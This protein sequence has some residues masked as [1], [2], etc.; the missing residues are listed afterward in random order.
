MDKPI[1][2]L[3]DLVIGI[4]QRELVEGPLLIYPDAEE[5]IQTRLN[6]DRIEALVR[7]IRKDPEGHPLR[8]SLLKVELLPYQLDGIAFVAG[9]GRA[10]LADDMGL[11]KTIQG[12][13]MAELLVQQA[14]IER[15]L[16]IGPGSIKSQWRNEIDR[17]CDRS[18]QVVLGGA[19]RRAQQYGSPV[20]FTIC[21]YEQVLR[22][23][24]NIRL[25]TWDLI[26]LDEGQR[27]KNWNTK[28]TQVVKS[29]K[30]TFALVL[31]GTPLENRL[32]DLYSVV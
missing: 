10:V 24:K 5:Y 23:S 7:E 21:N 6:L 3:P 12:I 27:I 18:C 26:I 20:F 2:G 28:T 13:G 29:L 11:G 32:E 25:H 8:Q 9:A 22:D 19:A 4:R 17:F 30:S 16:A 31:S 14:G 15:V 1:T